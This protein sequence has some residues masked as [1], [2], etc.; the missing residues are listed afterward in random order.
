MKKLLYFLNVFFIFVPFFAFADCPPP[1]SIIISKDFKVIAPSGYRY[2]GHTYPITATGPMTLAG[3]DLFSS[4]EKAM[5]PKGPY[6]NLHIEN[7]NCGYGI[8]MTSPGIYPKGIIIIANTT[9]FITNLDA[10][11]NASMR[12]GGFSCTAYLTECHFDNLRLR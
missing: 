7:I 5:T 11:W 2:V 8:G 12:E 3:V 9:P 10:N 1:E 4:T 6:K